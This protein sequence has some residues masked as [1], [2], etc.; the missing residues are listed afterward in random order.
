MNTSIASGKSKR[1]DERNLETRERLW[2]E[3]GEEVWSRKGS[4]GFTTIPRI[5]PLILGLITK[6]T[7]SKGGNP[8]MVYMDLW[9][10]INDQGFVEVTDEADFAYSA[11][12]FTTRATRTWKSH[13]KQ[14]IELGFVKAAVKGN[15]EFGYLL[16]LDPYLVAE[17][18]I[19]EGRV[20][21]DWC[22]A[23]H[24][25]VDQTGAVLPSKKKLASEK[26]K[27]RSVRRRVS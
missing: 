13:V 25:R 14:L 20:D 3:F 17:K 22:H 8:S 18:F 27:G 7:N 26:K 9:C 24:G 2:P 6:A 19:E 1:M 23:F 10:R 4:K 21:Q 11:G 16:L 5:L 12:Y 15:R